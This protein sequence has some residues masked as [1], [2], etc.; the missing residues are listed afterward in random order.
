MPGKAD[1]RKNRDNGKENKDAQR[2]KMA[3]TSSKGRHNQPRGDAGS[4]TLKAKPAKPMRM[5][6]T[7]YMD[8]AM[9]F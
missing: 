1:P 3:A 6:K 4:V 9:V 8:E 7:D 2:K 5:G